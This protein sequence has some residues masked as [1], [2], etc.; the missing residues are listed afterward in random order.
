[1]S[2]PFYVEA[3][4]GAEHELSFSA[5]LSREHE[6]KTISV[7]LTIVPYVSTCIPDGLINMNEEV[8]G[9]RW[10]GFLS[11]GAESGQSCLTQQGFFS[12][13]I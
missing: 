3:P 12:L 11:D 5:A 6:I 2:P 8:S 1:M 9:T 10:S 7:V 13:P 4:A